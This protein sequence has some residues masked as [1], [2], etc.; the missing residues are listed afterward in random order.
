MPCEPVNGSLV[1]SLLLQL[2]VAAGAPSAPNPGET[3]TFLEL[4]GAFLG[5]TKWP[6]AGLALIA[7]GIAISSYDG[8]AKEQSASFYAAF[9]LAC[10][11]GG[12]FLASI[13]AS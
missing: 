10:G 5:V 13:A 4:L 1:V 9:L 7:A 12:W 3:R 6:V 11:A 8:D 2:A